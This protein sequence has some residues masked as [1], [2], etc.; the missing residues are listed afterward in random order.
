M[1]GIFIVPLAPEH[2]V[3]VIFVALMAFVIVKARKWVEFFIEKKSTPE[4]S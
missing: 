2:W 3:Y 4:G 1:P